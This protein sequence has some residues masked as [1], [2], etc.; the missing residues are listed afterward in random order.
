MRELGGFLIFVISANVQSGSPGLFLIKPF[1][2]SNTISRIVNTKYI[3]WWIDKNCFQIYP[4]TID[5]RNSAKGPNIAYAWQWNLNISS[6]D[7]QES[8]PNTPA[9]DWQGKF[10]SGGQ[11]FLQS[12][13]FAAVMVYYMFISVL[14]QSISS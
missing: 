11:L 2:P 1:F 3:V 4:L 9:Q 5:N 13:N 10:C 14:L 12:R 8:I 6:T 7:W